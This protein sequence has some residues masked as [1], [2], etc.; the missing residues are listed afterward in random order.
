MP[1]RIINYN[2]RYYYYKKIC[3]TGYDAFDSNTPKV[4]NRIF[5]ERWSASWSSSFIINYNFWVVVFGHAHMQIQRKLYI[6]GT[7][8]RKK[9][10]I[11][12]TIS[13]VTYYCTKPFAAYNHKLAA[14]RRTSGR[15]RYVKQ[16]DAACVPERKRIP[17]IFDRKLFKFSFHYVMHAYGADNICTFI[18]CTVCI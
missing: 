6:V 17:H 16:K 10:A 5:F 7:K 2:I 15:A 12:W 8:E 9:V 14:A 4:L 18:M 3:I 1:Q 11:N 13:A